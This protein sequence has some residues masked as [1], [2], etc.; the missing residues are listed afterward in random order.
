MRCP[1]SSGGQVVLAGLLV[2]IPEMRKPL[3]AFPELCQS[4][5]A[6]VGQAVELY[7]HEVARLSGET[8]TA[9]TPRWTLVVNLSAPCAQLPQTGLSPGVP[10][11][12]PYTR[13]Q[14]QGIPASTELTPAWSLLAC[15][16]MAMGV[17]MIMP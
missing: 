12:M 2:L 7:P 6:L 15:G 8:C 13:Q 9:D 3:L 16:T 5:F 4:F 17:A 10:S 11:C 1:D 14:A